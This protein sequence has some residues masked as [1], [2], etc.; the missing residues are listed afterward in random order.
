MEKSEWVKVI[1]ILSDR[2]FNCVLSDAKWERKSLNEIDGKCRTAPKVFIAENSIL[3]SAAFLKKCSLLIGIDFVTMYLVAAVG[4]KCMGVFGCM[5]PLQTGPMPF[6]KHLIVK[7]N[8]IS[9]VTPED[10]VLKVTAW[11]GD[12]CIYNVFSCCV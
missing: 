9:Q 12:Y 7:K 1:D 11:A 5:N 2:D 4:M 8:D 6:E 3:D 10:I